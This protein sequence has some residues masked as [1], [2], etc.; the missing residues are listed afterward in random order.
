MRKPTSGP[1]GRQKSPDTPGV[2]W[3][4]YNYD[5]WSEVRAMPPLPRSL[6]NLKRGISEKKW[7]EARQWAGGRTAKAKYKMPESQKPDGMVAGSTKKLAS[8]VYQLKTGHC[9]T[10]QYLHRAKARPTAQ[11]WWCQCP[12]QTRDHLFKVCPKWKMQQKILWPEVLKETK[13][14]KSRWTVRD[15]LADERCVQ[16]VLDILADTDVGRLVPPLEEGDAESE[17]SAWEL[18]ER[19]KRQE[20]WVAEAEA[21]GA[22]DELGAGEERPLL[23]PTPPFMVPAGED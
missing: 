13:R 16:A 11:C 20:E 5:G 1:R 4:S 3:L 14:W 21:P 17:V 6:A 19:R 12:A 8:R 2:E 18:R 10:G 15:L 9:R 22:V 7:V 23:P